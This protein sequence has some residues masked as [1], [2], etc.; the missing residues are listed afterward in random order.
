MRRCNEEG[1]Y[2]LTKQSLWISPYGKFGK[3]VLFQFPKNQNE[4]TFFARASTKKKAKVE[5][6]SDKLNRYLLF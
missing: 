5:A 3:T 1:W 6:K 4:T 2:S